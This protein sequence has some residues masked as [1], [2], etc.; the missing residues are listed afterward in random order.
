MTVNDQWHRPNPILEPDNDKL[1]CKKCGKWCIPQ[2]L[3]P[4]V[5]A[6]GKIVLVPA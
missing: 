3:H 5:V 1:Q 2:S 6:G 4:C